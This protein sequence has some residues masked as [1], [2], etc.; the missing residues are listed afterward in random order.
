MDMPLKYIPAA[1]S[2]HVVPV[3]TRGKAAPPLAIQPS[4]K[5]PNQIMPVVQPSPQNY[6]LGPDGAY[7]REIARFQTAQKIIDVIPVQQTAHRLKTPFSVWREGWR[8][9]IVNDA[10]RTPRPGLSAPARLQS[11]PGYVVNQIQTTTQN[12]QLANIYTNLRAPG[13][14]EG[15]GGGCG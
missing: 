11:I 6:A 9:L 10:P 8:S 1:E 12:N 14:N 15:S 2:Q 5:K 3:R 7:T 4:I 13:I